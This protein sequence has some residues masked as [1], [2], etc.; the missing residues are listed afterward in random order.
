MSFGVVGLTNYVP[1]KYDFVTIGEKL[2]Y[3]HF[4]LEKSV[5]SRFLV[6][7]IDSTALHR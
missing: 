2:M 6:Q 3:Q 4:N 5:G 1:Q 7:A